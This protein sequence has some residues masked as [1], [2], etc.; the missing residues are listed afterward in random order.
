MKKRTIRDKVIEQIE[1]QEKIQQLANINIV[2][3]GNCGSVFLHERHEGDIECPFC[4]FIGDQCDCPDY[5]YSGIENNAEFNH[6]PIKMVKTKQI[7]REDVLSVAQ[8]INV[9]LNEAQIDIVL[10]NYEA[11]ADNDPTATWDLIVENI[12]NCFFV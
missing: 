8:S 11:E 1:L 3:C 2:N 10:E 5:L 7:C 4:D 6:E 9:S 12:I